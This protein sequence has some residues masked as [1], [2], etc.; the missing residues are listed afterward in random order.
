M[1]FEERLPTWRCTPGWA[2][3]MSGIC[4]ALVNWLRGCGLSVS[5]N[6]ADLRSGFAATNIH[7][8]CVPP[9]IEGMEPTMENLYER[10]TEQ[11]HTTGRDLWVFAKHG[12]GWLAVWRTMLDVNETAAQQPPAGA[13]G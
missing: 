13:A 11:F 1:T 6:H 5:T 4:Q 10:S 3:V 12:T 9:S 2:S 7:M 8:V